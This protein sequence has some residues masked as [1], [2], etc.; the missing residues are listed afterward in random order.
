MIAKIAVSAAVFAIDKPYDY[1]AP[2]GCNV[3][4]GMRVTVP[5]GRGNRISEGIVLSLEDKPAMESCKDILA[6]LDEQPVLDDFMLR[7]AAFVRERYFCTFYE[8][9]KAMLPAGLWFRARDQYEVAEPLE[10]DWKERTRRNPSAQLVLQAIV[11]CGG[12]ADYSALRQQ[13]CD[14]GALQKALRYLTEKKLLR[15]QTSLSRRAGDKVEKISELAVSPEEALAFAA[16]RRK[17]APLQ[18]AVLELLAASGSASSKDICYFT[19]ATPVVLR[20]LAELGYLTL[21]E[22][23]VLRRPELEPVA[24]AQPLELTPQQQEV[25]D[26]LLR[27]MQQPKPGAALLY[28]VTG[29]GKTLVYLQLIHQCLQ[30]GKSALV[31]VP[32]IALTP[33]LLRLFAAHFAGQVAVLHSALRLTERYDAWKQI[34]SGQARVVLGTRSAVFAPL[35]NPGLLILDE[36]QEHTYK[37]ENTPRYHA[38]EVAL[39][40]GLH[41]GAL[42]LLGSATPSVETM[43]QARTG[44]YALYRLPERYHGAALPEVTLV[45]LKQELRAGNAGALSRMLQHEIQQNLE[46]G[47][48]TIL[49]LNRRGNSRMLVCVDCGEVPQCPNCSVSLTYHSAN[50]RLMCHYCGHSEPVPVLCPACGGHLKPMGIGTQRL[51]QELKALWPEVPVLRMDADVIS[52]SNSHEKILRTF[53]R[54]QVPILIGT[55]MV[56]KGLDFENVTLVGVVDADQALYLESYR[57]AETTFAMLTQVAGRAGRGKKRGRAL[58]QTLTPQHTVLQ[59]AA[60]QDYDGFYQMEVELRQARQCPPFGDMIVVQFSGLAQEQVLQAAGTFR[61]MLDAALAQQPAWE[62]PPVILGPAPAAVARVN[63]RYRYRLTVRCRNSRLLRQIIA[64]QLRQFAGQKAFR[65]VFAGADCNPY[66]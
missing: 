5:F 2:E 17:T 20:R 8:A 12:K 23:Q 53:V 14:E 16:K 45:D 56:T 59:L 35:Q 39:Y 19:G 18:S 51:E 22:Q 25:C 27:Q 21:Q 47:E 61:Q 30:Q 34:Q 26:G 54:E 44:T 55:Q 65:G 1:R 42:V 28:G 10:P 60:R 31:L 52:A 11:Q 46:R 62:V 40:R 33:Q 13:F 36:E 7:L 58:I 63:N 49:F 48:Q 43:Y 66:E 6:V 32:E 4:P 37:S 57:A 15:S 24:P 38:R 50:R 29:A 41:Q 64:A 3:R 9:M